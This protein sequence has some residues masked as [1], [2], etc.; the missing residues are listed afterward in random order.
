MDELLEELLEKLKDHAKEMEET[1]EVY[2]KF[3]DSK[4]LGRNLLDKKIEDGILKGLGNAN[5]Y[6][7]EQMLTSY[8]WRYYAEP[9]TFSKPSEQ[10]KKKIEKEILRKSREQKLKRVLYGKNDPQTS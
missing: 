3:P 9:N 7:L 6:Q 4:E 5:M 1:L 10:V 8:R 2:K